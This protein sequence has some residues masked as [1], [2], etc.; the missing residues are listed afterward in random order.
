VDNSERTGEPN[1]GRSG[2]DVDESPDL[3]P[4][5]GRG[6]FVYRSVVA[7]KTADVF[8]WHERADALMDLSPSR[9]W[10]RIEKGP[11]G[12]RDGDGVT[13]S[14]GVGPFRVRWEARHFGY[15]RGS[16]FCDEQVR[17]PFKI[18]RHTHRFEPI[19]GDRTLYT[20]RVEYVV[21]GGPLV[22]RLADPIVRRLLSR[23][24]ARRHQIVRAAVEPR[25]TGA[26][27][28]RL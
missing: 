8:R 28:Q 25:V 11:E 22:E 14:I 5:S 15:I 23:L 10:T 7:G 13:F 20:D 18:W 19:D 27:C 26:S 16:Q 6:V 9:R 4:S 17:G 2:G 21:C 1:R 12:L 3:E 24:F